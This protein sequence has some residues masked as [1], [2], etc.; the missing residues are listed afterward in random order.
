MPT[1][2]LNIGFAKGPAT[3][4][5]SHGQYG[6]LTPQAVLAMAGT[7]APGVR[8]NTPTKLVSTLNGTTSVYLT[9]MG[10]QG[11]EFG[12]Q[13]IPAIAAVS[14]AQWTAGFQLW[15]NTL[16]SAQG[17]TIANQYADF[18]CIRLY[19]NDAAWNG[20][21]G[22][23]PGGG[24]SGNASRYYASLGTNL[25]GHAI[26]CAGTGGGLGTHDGTETDGSGASYQAYVATIIANVLGATSPLGNTTYIILNNDWSTA[27]L[28][29]NGQRLLPTSQG[30]A[31]SAYALSMFTQ[32]AALYKGNQRVIFE[33]H[34]EPYYSVEG[35]GGTALMNYESTLLG[36]GNN[37]GSASFTWPNATSIAAGGVSTYPV[38]FGTPI[39]QGG[40]CTLVSYQ[41]VLN[42]VR[43]QDAPNL[44]FLGCLVNSGGIFNW[45]QNGG[46]Q[47]VTDPY[48]VSGV[49]QYTAILHS[50]NYPGSAVFS[51]GKSGA[52]NILGLIAAGTPFVLDEYGTATT[53]GST[54]ANGYSWMKAN[55]VSGH[56][57][58]AVANFDG[59]INVGTGQGPTIATIYN[60]GSQSITSINPWA[61]YNV[62]NPS[63][64]A[65]QVPT[66]SN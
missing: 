65:S 23:D 43:A 4:Q 10:V 40:S 58:T 20:A 55:G 25:D 49:Q 26:Y 42:A 38:N 5:A 36:N 62:P 3:L 7:A 46:T 39:A 56:G 41:Q 27:V 66:G 12:L 18:N 14:S 57:M 37:G 28:A 47:S 60:Q 50:Y 19:L 32:L 6:I 17:T 48:T 29:S 22:A 1:P 31:I 21:T 8:V 51:N 63:S 11:G 44:V 45:S 13:W 61:N 59:N 34:N 33:F 2:T 35:T 9:L 24:P 16:Q 30:A 53:V 64:A 15:Y 54:G 52:Q